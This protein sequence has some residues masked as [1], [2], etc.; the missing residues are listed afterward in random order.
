MI[1]VARNRNEMAFNNGDNQRLLPR[2][3]KSSVTM[4]NENS[5]MKARTAR[6][7]ISMSFS[8]SKSMPSAGQRAEKEMLK[9]R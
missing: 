1:G 4:T 3:L 6:K 8:I 9:A 5:A 2:Q 7:A